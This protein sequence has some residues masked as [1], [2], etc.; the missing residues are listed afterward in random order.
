MGG[1]LG[2]ASTAQLTG[3]WGIGQYGHQSD[4]E[5]GLQRRLL[6]QKQWN[7]GV[8]LQGF[9][10]DAMAKLYSVLR[11][12]NVQWKKLGPYCLRCRKVLAPESCLEPVDM[13]EDETKPEEQVIKFEVQL[14]RIR[15]KEYT[16]DCQVSPF[17]HLIV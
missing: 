17:H 9:P 3:R 12:K 5:S 8:Y 7:L 6:A 13:T 16:L 10:Q 2:E 14:Y 11:S 15:N 1:E 4:P